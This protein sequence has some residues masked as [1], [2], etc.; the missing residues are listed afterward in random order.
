M[1]DILL[2]I[3]LSAKRLIIYLQIPFLVTS[4]ILSTYTFFPR[5]SAL[6][7]T[8]TRPQAVREIEALKALRT[9]LWANKLNTTADTVSDMNRM[10]TEGW[11]ILPQNFS[12]LKK[13]IW[14]RN[15]GVIQR[16]LVEP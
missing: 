10:L 12:K 13:I 2:L 1:F 6:R 5:E 15:K 3:I 7:V 16:I 14:G 4:R 8:V 11:K 9:G